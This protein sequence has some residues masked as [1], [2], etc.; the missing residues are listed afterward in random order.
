MG[1][2]VN[3]SKVNKHVLIEVLGLRQISN[4][5][6]FTKGNI[7]VLS[8]SIQNSHSW[9]DLRKVNLDRFDERKN[10][11]FLILRYYE[12]LL[13]I[14]LK[15]FKPRMTPEDKTVFTPNIGTHWKFNVVNHDG[16][17][18]IIN[19]QNRNVKYPALEV[20]SDELNEIIKW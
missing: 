6:I 2:N 20:T 15:E 7:F 5:T 1:S 17:Y 10:Q 16:G 11:G 12:K 4:T 3:S 13:F 19:Q 18:A 8:P 14:D 9:F